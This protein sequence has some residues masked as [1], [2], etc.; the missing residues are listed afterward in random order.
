MSSCEPANN[1]DKSD[2]CI[3]NFCMDSVR[4]IISLVQNQIWKPKFW[5]P[6]LVTVCA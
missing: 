6:T 3:D 2:T 4:T 5:L 1:A